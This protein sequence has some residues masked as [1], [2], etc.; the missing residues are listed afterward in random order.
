[1]TTARLAILVVLIALPLAAQQPN[2]DGTPRL[3]VSRFT[4]PGPAC[5]ASDV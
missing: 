5:E 1:M 4:T 2:N 3:V